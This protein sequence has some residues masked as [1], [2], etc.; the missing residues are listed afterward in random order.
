M[1]EDSVNSFWVNK[2]VLGVPNAI[3]GWV[4]AIRS[5]SPG[6]TELV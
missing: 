1:D 5:I 6:G 2:E 4:R 3:I